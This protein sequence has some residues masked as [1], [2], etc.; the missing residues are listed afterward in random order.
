MWHWRSARRSASRTWRA[1]T[2]SVS[3]V[4]ACS[5]SAR[6]ISRAVATSC[7]PLPSR[8]ASTDRRLPRS[9]PHPVGPPMLRC[10]RMRPTR[11]LLPMHRLVRI[12]PCRLLLLMPPTTSTDR[13]ATFVVVPTS[14]HRTLNRLRLLPRPCVTRLVRSLASSRV[15]TCRLARLPHR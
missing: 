10:V 8:S 13:L 9:A 5:T 4:C 3:T 2:S 1:S 11:V 6:F 14:K 7:L 12:K 15:P